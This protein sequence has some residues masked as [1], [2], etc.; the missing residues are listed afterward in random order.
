MTS[1]LERT[2]SWFQTNKGA[3]KEGLY[4]GVPY[5][6]NDST[7]WG[8]Y[9]PP[10]PNGDTQG[11]QPVNAPVAWRQEW[12]AR[13]KDLIDNYDPDM[14]YVDGGVPFPGDDQGKTGLEMLAYL[15]NQ[16]AA[17]HNGRDQ[18]VMCIKDWRKVMPN[19]EWGHYWEGI[20]TLDLE[21]SRLPKI[22][23]EPWQTDTS[24][25]PWT[26]V[27]GAKYRSA[28]EIIHE[29]VDIVSKNGNMLLN[30]SP[31]A[32]GL[33]DDNAYQL[34]KEIGAWMK[35]NGE[36][37]YG[38]RPWKA[39][40]KD[41]VRI[42]TKGNE[43]LYI[44]ILEKPET[45]SLL[46]NYMIPSDGKSVDIQ[47]VSVLGFESK[48][49]KWGLSSD[50]LKIELPDSVSNSPALVLRIKG[51]GF[52]N[53]DEIPL[54]NL[55][56]STDELK[57]WWA[58]QRIT[59]LDARYRNVTANSQNRIWAVNDENLLVELINGEEVIDRTIRIIDLG[60]YRNGFACIDED[61]TVHKFESGIGWST[62][63]GIKAKRIDVD[64]LKG[65]VWVVT[66]NGQVAYFGNETWNLLD[67]TAE[68]IGVGNRGNVAI[69]NK[70][71]LEKI[72]GEW[73]KFGGENLVAIDI[74][75]KNDVMVTVDKNGAVAIHDG[76][77]WASI[78]TKG[79]RYKDLACGSRND[80][81]TVI[82][83]DK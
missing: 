64:A 76:M 35:V 60:A 49:V 15:Y 37:I 5:D 53:F 83:L 82:L 75:I 26:Y 78:D 69:I 59:K 8:L 67:K 2:W 13:C 11:S 36:S 81:E 9:L 22:R 80:D 27:K 62:L 7:Y 50:G 6:G 28:A 74:S 38:T 20:A 45:N 77:N 14:F 23:K 70:G 65:I 66:Q 41:N 1:H 3:D 55:Y 33:L 42:V 56:D 52:E 71:Q 44:T 63:P 12:L 25:G 54:A 19:G 29:L 73:Q 32:N 79:Q 16:N 72:E 40:G 58:D 10:D 39:F 51:K 43:L 68:D 57:M 61:G 30:V 31:M 46:I 4:A 21:R 47:A 17:R 48:E 34:L 18:A 24:I